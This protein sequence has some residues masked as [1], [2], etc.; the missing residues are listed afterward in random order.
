MPEP[1]PLFTRGVQA[2]TAGQWPY[3]VECFTQVLADLP[4]AVDARR[5]LRQALRKQ[6]E[7]EPANA[8]VTSLRTLQ[9]WPLAVQGQLAEQRK[10]WAAAASA[11][12]AFCAEASAVLCAFCAADIA[13]AAFCCAESA[14][15]TQRRTW[16]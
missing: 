14:V 6:A 4:D 9:A 15:A 16:R 11:S 13:A 8:F 2:L 10:Q 3:A 5:Y 7:A 12:C 1:H